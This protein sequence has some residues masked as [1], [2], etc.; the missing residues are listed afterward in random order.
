MRWWVQ[1]EREGASCKYEVVGAIRAGGGLAV[2]MRRWVQSE[3]EGASCKYEV[4]GAIR[5]GGG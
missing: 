4:V 1:S 2:S 3:R 5:A